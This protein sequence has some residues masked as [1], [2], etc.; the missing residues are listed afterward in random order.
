MFITSDY[1]SGKHKRNCTDEVTYQCERKKQIYFLLQLQ[2]PNMYSH[3]NTY[4]QFLIG[5]TNF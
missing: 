5:F 4:S 2:A 3:K 1:I